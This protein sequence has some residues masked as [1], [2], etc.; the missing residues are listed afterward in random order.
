M[1][2]NIVDLEEAI[3]LLR[4]AKFYMESTHGDDCDLYYEI[5]GFVEQFN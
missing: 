4:E 2:E 1:N 3:R 5:Q